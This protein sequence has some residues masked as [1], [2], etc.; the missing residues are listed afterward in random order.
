[1]TAQNGMTMISHFSLSPYGGCGDVGTGGRGLRFEGV[2]SRVG[3][4][5]ETP[6]N[7]LMDFVCNE[8]L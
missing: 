5:A 6:S 1:M 2:L 8:V 7:G 3:K 4:V